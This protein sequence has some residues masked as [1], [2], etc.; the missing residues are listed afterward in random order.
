V[1][2]FPRSSLGRSFL[3]VALGSVALAVVLVS[4]LSLRALHR[5]G[6]FSLGISASTV[7]SQ[8]QRALFALVRER[9]QRHEAL[10]RSAASATRTLAERGAYH[11]EHVDIFGVRNAWGDEPL[12]FRADKG[13]FCNPPHALVSA[14]Y[15]GGEAVAPETRRRGDALSH[16]DKSLAS[17]MLT[18]PGAVA[19]W[20]MLDD[21]VIRYFPNV[22]L[23]ERMAARWEFDYRQDPCYLL[24]TPRQ[25]PSGATRW[26]DVYEDTVGQGL[27]V[28]VGTPFYTSDG[29]FQGVVGLDFSLD[30]VVREVLQDRFGPLPGADGGAAPETRGF[31]VLLA[32]GGGVIAMPLDRAADLGL[33][34][35]ARQELARG[36]ALD[37][38]LTESSEPDVRA[39]ALA[40]VE[41]GR[42]VRRVT[43]GGRA[44][45]AAFHPLRQPGWSLAELVP[46]E[47]VLASV[48]DS[49]AA[50][51]QELRALA[52][53]LPFFIVAAALVAIL[54]MMWFLG[55]RLL[56]PLRALIEATQAVSRGDLGHVVRMPCD[57][58]FGEVGRAFNSMTAELRRNQERLGE[59]QEK[60][61]GIFESAVEGIY[62]STPEGVFLNVNQAMARVL[63]YDGPEELM[64]AVRTMP[65]RLYVDPE[66]RALFFE[67]LRAEGE[68]LQFETRLRRRDGGVIW[69]RLGGRA[70]YGPGGEVVMV[71]GV[72]ED[73]TDVKNAREQVRH[74]SQELMRTQE[75]ERGRIARDLHDGVAQ[76]LSSLKI[77]AGLLFDG[78][79]DAPP[80]VRRRAQDFSAR[81]QECIAAVRGMAYDLRPSG[82]DELGLLRTLEQYCREFTERTGIRAQF[83]AAGMDGVVLAPEAEINLYRLTQEALHNVEKHSGADRAEVRLV[84]S[85]PRVILSVTDNGRGFD[86]AAPPEGSRRRMGLRS[87]EERARLL[88]GWLD[89]ASQPGRG[90]RIK[91]QVPADPAR[92]QP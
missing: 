26:S 38:R 75:R 16:L 43:L 2:Q 67:R 48:S 69:A 56:R 23:A 47:E 28:T 41:G 5:L 25:N 13:L 30:G 84:A 86:P 9:A 71:N 52:V 77:A 4:L 31:G 51:G 60:Y 53:G 76:T 18:T 65:A 27:V 29:L 90:V 42:G 91:V 61:R 36:Q 74:L 63:G 44:Y 35:A 33:E 62:Q 22:N 68:V 14:V 89:V 32:R 73:F 87:M 17:A 81:L 3:F 58:E 78:H 54:L 70:V 82:L 55:R 11:L 57:D 34:P 24:G 59:A 7:E 79:P 46:L 72:L 20:F 37:C 66:D 64:Q 50:L 10:F 49:R 21:A 92:P 83:M 80:E 88:G 40:M 45:L 1:K 12:T 19:A 85:H 6:E 39:L 8:A 15:W